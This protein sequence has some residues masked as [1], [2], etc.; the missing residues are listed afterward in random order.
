MNYNPKVRELE[1][2]QLKSLQTEAQGNGSNALEELTT[3]GSRKLKQ[4]NRINDKAKVND[5]C[6]NTIEELA[7]QMSRTLQHD[8]RRTHI[9][10]AKESVARQLKNLQPKRQ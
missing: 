9:P 5:N 8:N 6:I 10:K 3:E 2:M 7:N 1:T 4:G